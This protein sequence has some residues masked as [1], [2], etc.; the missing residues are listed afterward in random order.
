MAEQASEFRPCGLVPTYD[1]PAT[2]GAVVEGLLLHLASVIVVDD[3]SGPTARVV[4]DELAARP[5]VV[6]LRR[7][8]NAGKGRAV[9][10]GLAEAARLGFTHAMQVDADGQHDLGQ[11]PEL[12]DHARA[13]PEALVLAAPV[14]DETVPRGRRVGR[15]LTKFWTRVET[16]G[17][18]IADPMCGFRVYPVAAALRANARGERMDFDPEIAVR[19][20]WDAV[21]IVNLPSR[22]RYLSREQGGVSHFRM[23][24]DNVAISVMHTRLC[25]ELVLRLLSGRFRRARPWHHEAET[26]TSL[27]IRLVRA[28]ATLFGR[29]AA[30]AL[31][32]PIA[33]YYALFH[34]RVRLASR[35]FLRRLGRPSGFSAVFV[36]V[37]RFAQCTLDRWYL[38]SN[39]FDAFDFALEGHEH[40][41]A[42]QERKR[43]ALLLGAHLGSFEAGRLMS[44][45]AGIPIHALGWFERR[46]RINAELDRAGHNRGPGYI[47]V[48]PDDPT[49]LFRVREVI[50][51]GECVA[52]LG[53][54][55][56]DEQ[57]HPVEFLGGT[58]RFPTGPYRLAATLGCPIYLIV[59]LHFPPNRYRLYC[60]PFLE[61]VAK[62]RVDPEAAQRAAQAFA[63]RLEHYCHMAPDNWFNFYAFWSL[64]P[65]S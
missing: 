40:L 43:G 27:G 39:R 47:A 4:L 9:K 25:C 60:E 17:R 16:L 14:F 13:R 61:H 30:R 49:Y 62:G 45:R 33:G 58:A 7:A 42:L 53:D 5:G 15:E 38:L 34:R 23:W 50:S 63:T 21:P 28:V 52:L 22:V 32:V 56:I 11:V 6:L 20:A 31:L 18:S 37:L 51:R 8:S 19:M 10:E 35:E 26:G 65:L 3:A 64:P 59:A 55:C 44:R 36:N 57:G 1:N 46:G 12:L 29:A 48:D 54:R 41:Q 2:I 24:R